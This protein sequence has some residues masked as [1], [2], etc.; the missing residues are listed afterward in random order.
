M[1]KRR[2][3]KLYSLS[4]RRAKRTGTR[5]VPARCRDVG[6][7]GG[8]EMFLNEQGELMAIWGGSEEKN[9]TIGRPWQI[10]T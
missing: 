1:K 4:E 6:D 8:K 10:I 7:S 3:G 2:C 9:N 5:G